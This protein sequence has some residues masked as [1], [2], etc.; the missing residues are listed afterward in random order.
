MQ[1]IILNI[2][3]C[4]FKKVFLLYP[5]NEWIKDESHNIISYTSNDNVNVANI[6]TYNKQVSEV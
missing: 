4:R 6:A 3:I 1:I 5:Y 2:N